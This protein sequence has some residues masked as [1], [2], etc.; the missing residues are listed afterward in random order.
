VRADLER[1]VGDGAETDPLQAHDRVPDG[2]AHV[3]DLAGAPFVDGNRQQRLILPGA[4]A[5]LHHADHRRRGAAALDRHAAPQALERALAGHAADARV[6]LALD[7]VAR[8]QQPRGEL[9]V[10]GQQQ[11]AFRVVVQPA[12]RVD[13][14]AHVRQEV[15]HGR[16]VLRVLPRGHVPAG[17]VEQDVAAARRRAHALAVDA[18]VVAVGVGPAAELGYRGAVHRHAAV[19]DQ[20]LRRAPRRDAGGGEDLLEAVTGTSFAHVCSQ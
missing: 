18:D 15:E 2:V 7:L 17:L 8:V 5:R 10:V 1:A 9:A 3:A 19:E 12:N 14:L 11:Q 13:V 6:V 20:P 4:E 16:P